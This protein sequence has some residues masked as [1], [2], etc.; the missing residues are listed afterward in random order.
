MIVLTRMRTDSQAADVR[1]YLA[2]QTVGMI[3]GVGRPERFSDGRYVR[4]V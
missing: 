3:F 2:R 4:F 1:M